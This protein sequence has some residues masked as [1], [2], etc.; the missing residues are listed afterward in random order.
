MLFAACVASQEPPDQGEITP[1]TDYHRDDPHT[2]EVEKTHQP[3]SDDEKPIEGMQ[4]FKSKTDENHPKETQ[5]IDEVNNRLASETKSSHSD[6]VQ[7]SKV[8]SNVGEGEISETLGEKQVVDQGESSSADNSTTGAES[9]VGLGLNSFRVFV[10]LRQI[11]ES[12][13]DDFGQ[14]VEKSVE[15]QK[16]NQTEVNETAV[17]EIEN[18][19]E[20]LAEPED[21]AEKIKNITEPLKNTKFQCTGRNVSENY[22]NVVQ[23][24]NNTGL[25]YSLNFEKNESGADCVLVLF[26]APW[27]PFCAEAGPSFNALARAFPQLD[28]L[29]VDAAHFSKYVSIASLLDWCSKKLSSL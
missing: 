12:F 15:E 6:P 21:I 25:L 18:K 9:N 4:T 26:Y 3:S 19:T 11:V 28:I 10:V 23:I 8:N 7:D 16:E 24:V 2:N 17:V 14:D 29:A 20:I 5:Q 13:I 1:E 27:C 22:T